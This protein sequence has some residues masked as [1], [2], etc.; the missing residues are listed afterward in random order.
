MMAGAEATA[1]N[2]FGMETVF[3]RLTSMGVV[4]ADRITNFGVCFT[5]DGGHAY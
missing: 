4:L 5:F 3:I 1:F 2:R